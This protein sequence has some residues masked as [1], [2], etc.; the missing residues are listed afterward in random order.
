MELGDKHRIMSPKNDE[1]YA[2]SVIKMQRKGMR[3][4]SSLA[5]NFQVEQC[6]FFD[7]L[8]TSEQ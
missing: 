1:K 6:I 4:V 5:M 7:V 3:F 2:V 8:S